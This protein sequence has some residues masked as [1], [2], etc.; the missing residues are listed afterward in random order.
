MARLRDPNTGCPW[1]LR[2]TPK[3]LKSYV[4]EEAYE[5]V[6][7]IETGDPAALKD[8]LGDL[9]FQVVFLAQLAKERDWFEFDDVVNAISDKLETRH[10]HV[11]GDAGPMTEAEI[12]AAWEASKAKELADKGVLSGL[13]G[14]LPA[15]HKAR[16][17]TDKA[18]AVG[19]EWPDIDGAWA[20]FDEEMSELREATQSGDPDAIADELGDTLFTLVNLARWLKVDPEDAL[21]RTCGKFVYRF[22]YVESKLRERGVLMGAAS[23]EEMDG[24]WNDAKTTEAS[25]E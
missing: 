21:Q 13:P 6:E 11:F 24:L 1:D 25:R 19:F 16:R 7:A 4:V 8:E 23:L 10:P 3:S 15:L 9:L 5:V 22:G 20:K 18:A 17:L 14:A 12:G 2:Q